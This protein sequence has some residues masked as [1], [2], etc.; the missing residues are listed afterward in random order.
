MYQRNSRELVAVHLDSAQHNLG[1]DLHVSTNTSLISH[2]KTNKRYVNT[3]CILICQKTDILTKSVD[4]HNIK[5]HNKQN[6]TQHNK[7]TNG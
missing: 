1:T 7:H 6:I 3:T 5:Q 2:N 4:K